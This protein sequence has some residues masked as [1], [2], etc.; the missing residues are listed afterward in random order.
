MKT[1]V[2]ILAAMAFSLVAFSQKAELKTAEKALKKGDFAAAKTALES[3]SSLIEGAD[4]KLKAQYYFAKG[5][6]YKGLSKGDFDATTEAIDSYKM[7]LAEEERTGKKK[8]SAIVEKE[9]TAMTSEVI[10]SAVEDNKAKNYKEAAS[11]LYMGYQMSPKDTLYLFHAASSAVTGGE[12]E[13]ALKY[14]N[15]LKTLDYDGG[16]VKYTALNAATG[17]REEMAKVQRDLM[18]KSK[19]FTEPKD[20]KIPSKRSEIIKNIALIYT[21]LG[22]D[23]KALEAFKDARVLYPNDVNLILSQA[24]LYFKQGDKDKFKELM[25]EAQKIAPDN[26]DLSYNIGV[27]NMEQGNLEEARVAYRKT[28][29]IDPSYVNASLNISTSYVNEGNALVEVMNELGNSR[30]D[31]KK[32]DELKAQKDEMFKN[33]ASALEE[34]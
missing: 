26:A 25:G 33:G 3:A 21:Q 4:D 15:E 29:E 32:Y 27:I 11:K 8:Y 10:N 19:S 30:A 12:Y 31:I 18:V 28:L 16:G 23:D 7:L 5:N 24:N 13:Q 17:E 1:R 20:E 9:L 2:S 34:S 14:Y 6:T 22:Q